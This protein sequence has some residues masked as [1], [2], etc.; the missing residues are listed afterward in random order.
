MIRIGPLI[1]LPMQI[2]RLLAERAHQHPNSIAI[3]APGYSPLSFADLYRHIE[4][5]VSQLRASGIGRNDRVATIL[6]NGPEMAVAFL[7][8]ASGATSAPLNPAYRAAEFEFYLEDLK[9]KAMLIA[10]E[11]DSPAR[12][13]ARSLDIPIFELD[14]ER[15]GSAGAFSFRPANTQPLNQDTWADSDD[16][17]LVLHTSGTTSKPKL[18]PLTH[19][20]L[21][22]SAK[23]I[24]RALALTPD[25]V[26]LNVMPLF[27]IHGLMAAVLASLTAGARVVCTPG[28]LAPRFFDWLSDFRPTWYT[29]VPTMHQQILAHA[30]G[31][32]VVTGYAPLRFVRSSSAA[33]PPSV[34]S[35]LESVFHAPVLE[36]YG[37]TEAAHQMA[38]NPLPP[39]ARKAGSVGLPAGPEIAIM[40]EYGELL[41]AELPG[42]IVI[43]G[44]NVMRGY[45]G[46]PQANAEAFTN[47]WFR[48]G[49]RG[50]R[51]QEGYLFITG[52]IKELIN[53]AGEKIAPREVDQVL[54]LHP[55]VAQAV[56]FA[57]PDRQVGEEVAAAVVLRDQGGVSEKELREFAATRLA[58]FK[59][60]RRVVILDDI[61]LGPTGKVQRIGLA[62]RLGLTAEP[63]PDAKRER[64]VAPH[65]ALEIALAALWT[66]TLGA[67]RIGIHDPFLQ[68]G[69]DSILAAQLLSRVDQAF[70]IEIPFISIFD[71]ASTIAGM[72]AMVE[73]ARHN[74]PRSKSLPTRA[75]KDKRNPP[76][77]FVQERFWFLQQ[78]EPETSAFNRPLAFRLKGA[79]D[80]APLQQSF[81]EIVRRHSILRSR[82][83]S[84]DGQPTQTILPDAPIPLN[85]LDLK[86]VPA[87]IREEELQRALH[88]EFAKPFDLATDGPLRATLLHLD[89]KEYLLLV[90][91]HHSA[92]DG[93]SDVVLLRELSLLYNAFVKGETP[94]LSDIR[95]EYSDF[96]RAERGAVASAA[97]N[98]SLGYWKQR[99]GGE[100]PVLELPTD[101]PRPSILTH[102]GANYRFELPGSVMDS[103]NALARREGATP[104]M[105]LFAAFQIL[106]FRYTEQVDIVVGVPAAG[107]SSED[108]EVLL[109]CF[110]Q[111]LVLRTDLSGNPPFRELLRRVRKV[112][113]GA[114]AHQDIPFEKLVLEL[115][116]KRTLSRT[117]LFQVLF[118]LRN[119]PAHPLALLGLDAKE[120][121]FD[122]EIAHLDLAMELEEQ[123]GKL[124][125]V[126]AY[127]TD[128]FD[129]ETI[130]RMV[131]HYQVL[132]S[133]VSSAP[134]TPIRQLPILTE[135]E[136]NQILFEWNDTYSPF[137]RDKRIHELI[138][139]WSIATPEAVAVVFQGES[140]THRE[141]N[142]RANQLAHY[143]GERGVGPEVLV[144]IALERSVEM[145]VSALAVL[146]AGGAYVPLDP[147]YPR[148][149]LAYMLHDT[150]A[151]VLIT[152]TS[153]LERLPAFEGNL[154]RLDAEHEAIAQAPT[155]NP[156]TPGTCQNLAYVMYTSGS[157]G[158][159]KGVM[160][161]HGSIVNLATANQLELKPSDSY[162]MVAISSMS[163]DGWVYEIFLP[164]TH[165]GKVFLADDETVYDGA[166]LVALLEASDA[167]MFDARP[168][169]CQLMLGAGWNGK[170]QLK[171]ALGGEP[172]ERSLAEHLLDLGMFIWNPYGPTEATVEV[173]K[174]R[175]PRGMGPVP[176]GK[177]IANTQLYI[178]DALMQPVPVGVQGDLY[179]GGV[180]LARGYLNR[181][182]L[183]SE[184]FV[185]NPFHPSSRLYKTGD[186]SRYLPDGNLE[187]LGRQDSQIK[188]HGYRIELGEI[189]AA[190]STQPGVSSAV[191]L[192]REDEPGN[193]RLVAYVVGKAGAQTNAGELRS[194][195]A[196]TLPS[197]MLPTTFILL[198]RFPTLPNG[199]LDRLAL[200]MPSAPL[201]DPNR[202]PH[203][204]TEAQI[205]AIWAQVLRVER[206]GVDSTFFELGG[207]SL[208]AAQVISRLR[209][210]FNCDIPLRSIFERPTVAEMALLID[211]L[212]AT[213]TAGNLPPL[214][215][216]PRKS[217]G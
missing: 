177:P 188:L 35:E 98:E 63:E 186:R 201:P 76:L 61:P 154:V 164:L 136:R 65:S 34:M 172:L 211:Q 173:T 99:L 100:L 215:R 70:D 171:I 168:S 53:R 103:L 4:Q 170:P 48:T 116:P 214:I 71:D 158:K 113:L 19:T 115:N 118:Q 7:G 57:L 107:R 105:F 110:M 146:K 56:T 88:S 2:H 196:Q 33:L 68:V 8:V 135:Q 80:V 106:L 82:I 166:K 94:S 183:T 92:F 73:H 42:E 213:G 108:A 175:V 205:A 191:V 97:W 148:E 139:Q 204:A 194:A 137:P 86:G 126:I 55:R 185:P 212:A 6:P 79:L 77:S 87:E 91:T 28:F 14:F 162:R 72:A 180:N 199:K 120:W 179:I 18:V 41:D 30:R 144:G 46:N 122:P 210:A 81:N 152:Q 32:E 45:D 129:R 203:T 93:W 195:L 40:G 138:E 217:R 157:T 49:D 26:C 64:Y 51:D 206:V 10:R 25:D 163:F 24:A 209:E 47:G 12:A 145:V 184:R 128:L 60:P 1:Y 102:R 117:P 96:A 189:E 159:P 112:A 200:P 141:L 15:G 165:G 208:I 151:P 153:L 147:M 84:V 111:T 156:Q 124:R 83:T 181:P 3:A 101:R 150:K 43:R 69:G 59:V 27:H 104:F 132:L 50:Y 140:R 155:T 20:N 52:R 176:I 127:N 78:L 197:Y 23:N 119:L 36:A 216:Q 130:E 123:E 5:V 16:V 160:V 125:G 38:S 178:L 85:Q 167:T 13:A 89:V 74:A 192:R 66:E 54:L 143:L 44:E 9:A 22:T 182:E 21:C 29:A 31:K 114:Y 207:S 198:E 190:I 90:V 149:R 39:R 131:H 17:A 187:F 109:G 67:A 75:V 193:P 142:E 58:D 11:M 202:I 95:M 37:M 134:D 62:D 174:Y 121:Y 169:V 133:A 161:Q